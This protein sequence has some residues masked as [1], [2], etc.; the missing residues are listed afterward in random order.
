MRADLVRVLTKT[1]GSPGSRSALTLDQAA[2]GVTQCFVNGTGLLGD[3][4]LL[5]RHGRLSRSLALVVLSLEELGKAL[6][7]HVM[8]LDVLA[9]TQAD[10]ASFWKAFRDHAVKQRRIASYGKS[11]E[12]AWR[13]DQ[14]LGNP[15]PYEQ[16]LPQEIGKLLDLAKQRSFYADFVNGRFLVPGA[17]SDEVPSILDELFAFA[18]ERAD[19]FEWL[20]ATQDR[21]RA[22]L[23]AN[24]AGK[25]IDHGSLMNGTASLLLPDLHSLIANRS[26]AVVPDYVSTREVARE[27]LQDIPDDVVAAVV[28]AE[29]RRIRERLDD[30]EFLPTS[31]FRGWRMMKLLS[32]I[33][34]Q[35]GVERPTEFNTS[36]E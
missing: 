25:P 4:R 12:D 36:P 14:F 13:T 29:G 26:S 18:E 28:M 8:S 23:I 3:A 10:W 11:F 2:E 21:S 30:H 33:A 6:E 35:H 17:G 31:A 9:G 34:E 1:F 32:A 5:A 24:A 15:G 7:L 20:H 19:S 27:Q 22:V 16:F